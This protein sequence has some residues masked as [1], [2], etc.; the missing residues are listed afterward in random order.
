MGVVN[1]VLHIVDINIPYE[2]Y[3]NLIKEVNA[4]STWEGFKILL[5]G[6]VIN[7]VSSSYTLYHHT[8]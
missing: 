5:S 7:K 1:K 6:S 8:L 3:P 4:I 2:R